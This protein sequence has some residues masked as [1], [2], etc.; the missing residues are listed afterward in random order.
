MGVSE[1]DSSP[2]TRVPA[3]VSAPQDIWRALEAQQGV[4]KL[5]SDLLMYL[6]AGKQRGM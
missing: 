2:K 5:S 6:Q 4:S 3:G 1:K